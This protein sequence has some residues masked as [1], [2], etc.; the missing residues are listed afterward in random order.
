M[1]NDDLTTCCGWSWC[2]T[3]YDVDWGRWVIAVDIGVAADVCAPRLTEGRAGRHEGSGIWL[4]TLISGESD[5]QELT[6]A[7]G[8]SE[9]AA[10]GT[11]SDE[12]E[13]FE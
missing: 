7:D 3:G 13:S 1:L 12:D 4:L 10:E 9:S 5:G 6:M 11:V 8:A 2:T